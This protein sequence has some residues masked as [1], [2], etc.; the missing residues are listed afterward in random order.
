MSP[1]PCNKTTYLHG[2]GWINFY[3]QLSLTG[4]TTPLYLL[5]LIRGTLDHQSAVD[6]P[7]TLQ[8]YTYLHGFGCKAAGTS[9]SIVVTQG[10]LDQSKGREVAVPVSKSW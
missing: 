8:N 4:T 2:Y 5:A 7:A 9:T 10:K 3:Y 6:V 1:L